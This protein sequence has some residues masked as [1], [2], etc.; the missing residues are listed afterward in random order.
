MYILLTI[1]LLQRNK[2]LIKVNRTTEDNNIYYFPRLLNLKNTISRKGSTHGSETSFYFSPKTTHDAPQFEHI[3][4]LFR[5]CSNQLSEHPIDEQRINRFSTPALI[6]LVPKYALIH[7]DALE[8]LLMYAPQTTSIEAKLAGVC[9]VT[10]AQ[11]Q[12]I[13]SRKTTLKPIPEHTPLPKA[14]SAPALLYYHMHSDQS[15]AQKPTLSVGPTGEVTL[16][17][18]I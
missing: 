14:T 3:E 1:C 10:K 13:Y 15:D 2:S 18:R 4:P 7:S 9:N 5:H 12:H 6:G 17:N 8:M 16:K 11:E